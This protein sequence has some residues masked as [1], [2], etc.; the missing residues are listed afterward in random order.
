[1]GED[2]LVLAR[3]MLDRVRT[4]LAVVSDGR[5]RHRPRTAGLVVIEEN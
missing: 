3:V 4:R 5:R 2:T 1:M